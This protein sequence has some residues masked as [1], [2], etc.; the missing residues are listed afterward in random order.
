MRARHVFRA[1]RQSLRLPDSS[2]D[3]SLT[4]PRKVHGEDVAS[5]RAAVV[6]LGNTN[7]KARGGFLRAGF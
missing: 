6:R 2:D 4:T 1:C 5:R 3:G 7:E